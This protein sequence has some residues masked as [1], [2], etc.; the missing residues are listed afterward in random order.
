MEILQTTDY[1]K[2]KPV[3]GNRAIIK[4]HVQILIN[5][6]EKKNL[7]PFNPIKVN[8]KWE[9]IDGQHRLKAAEVLK[10]PI[11]YV[12]TEKADIT[13]VI[14]E[15]THNKNWTLDDYIRSYAA[16]G[17]EAYQTLLRF[18]EEHKI[19]VSTAIVLLQFNDGT[20]RFSNN[21]KSGGF[22]IVD[23]KKSM[24]IVAIL[25]ELT[26]M[27][28]RGVRLDREFSV[29]LVRLYNLEKVD[30]KKMMSKFER[31]TTAGN[32]FTPQVTT[33]DY[34]RSFEAIYNYHSQIAE[35]IY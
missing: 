16:R 3:F 15:N 13:D 29:A 31:W 24:E 20:R 35:S 19:A 2:F 34:L 4:G 28:D 21:V 17:V 23:L 9:V 12:V 25:D 30:W 11:Y 8:E 7:L 14:M 18:A 26:P 10:T 5:A 32:Q 22:T 6:I 33:L 27:I 1:A